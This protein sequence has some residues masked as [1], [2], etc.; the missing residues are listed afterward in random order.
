MTNKTAVIFDFDGVIADTFDA[1]YKVV[2]KACAS[3]VTEEDYRDAYSGNIYAWASDPLLHSR[4]CRHELFE[5]LLP[6]YVENLSQLF[7]G[8]DSSLAKLALK[9]D[10]HVVTSNSSLVAEAFLGKYGLRGLFGEVLGRDFSK[11]KVV[12]LQ[13]LQDVHGVDK[14]S[15]VYITDTVGDI[16]E[17]RDA[18]YSSL[19]VTW[20][21]CKEEPLASARPAG[22]VRSTVDLPGAVERYF[23]REAA[24]LTKY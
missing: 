19:A 13:K 1:V 3:G 22:I 2:E 9:Y 12:K 15:S 21:Y 17:V 18:G 24:Y 14:S 23:V 20:G 6:G 11:S 16:L 10:L 7:L 5:E 8:I 4:G